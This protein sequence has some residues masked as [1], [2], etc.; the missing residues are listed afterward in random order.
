MYMQRAATLQHVGSTTTSQEPGEL[1]QRCV[2][3]VAQRHVTSHAC[4]KAKLSAPAQMSTHRTAC[5]SESLS[6]SSNA[7]LPLVS[8]TC[9]SWVPG[10]IALGVSKTGL[11][12]ASVSREGQQTNR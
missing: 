4:T 3:T 9:G 12:L 10:V 11:P 6:V 8:P 7:L 5:L 1:A 2:G